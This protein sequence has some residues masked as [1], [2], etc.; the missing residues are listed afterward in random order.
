[1]IGVVAPK[2]RDDDDDDESHSPLALLLP[3]LPFPQPVVVA[4]LLSAA[5]ALAHAHA[6]ARCYAKGRS[7]LAHRIQPAPFS[8]QQHPT[9]RKHQHCVAS[10]RAL[11]AG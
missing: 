10:C 2:S 6:H 3:P 1:M 7:I 8:K 11:E 9:K 4:L 5:L